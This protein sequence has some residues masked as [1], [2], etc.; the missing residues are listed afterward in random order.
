MA[1]LT[2]NL[3]NRPQGSDVGVPGIGTFENGK[4]HEVPASVKKRYEA[5]GKKFPRVIG[6][7]LPA[8]VEP[9]PEPVYDYE[10][11]EYDNA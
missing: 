3:P 2:V 5:R 6:E 10:M 4:E 11:K 9:D 7:P 8:P 1:K